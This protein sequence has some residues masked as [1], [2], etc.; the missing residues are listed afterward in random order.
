MT[1]SQVCLKLDESMTEILR[2]W[3]SDGLTDAVWALMADGL[4]WRMQKFT[5]KPVCTQQLMWFGKDRDGVSGLLGF[6][7]EWDD[8]CSTDSGQKGCLGNTHRLEKVPPGSTL[9]GLDGPGSV[10]GVVGDV[11]VVLGQYEILGP[12]GELYAKRPAQAQ[13]EQSEE[14]E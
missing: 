4:R 6:Y 5:T 10:G 2:F 13:P 1:K 8:A 12:D 3:S 9:A 7:R 14:G 11:Y